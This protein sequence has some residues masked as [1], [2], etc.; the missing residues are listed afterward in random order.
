VGILTQLQRAKANELFARR[1]AYAS[2][3]NLAQRALEADDVNLA[4]RLLAKHRP[5]GKAGGG[6]QKLI[7]AVGN[8]ATYGN[9]ANPT[10]PSNSSHKP[11]PTT[12]WRFPRMGECW[13]CKRA[14]KW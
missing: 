6:K 1:T 9:Y 13:R 10:N 2:D 4:V 11:I 7:C 3:I 5:D 8:G 14:E 12:K